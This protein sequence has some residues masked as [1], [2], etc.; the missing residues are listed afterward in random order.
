MFVKELVVLSQSLQ[1]IAAKGIRKFY[2]FGRSLNHRV[3][4]FGM[5]DEHYENGTEPYLSNG[6]G[7]LILV[8][9]NFA[10]VHSYFLPECFFTT[11]VISPFQSFWEM[12]II[13]TV[14]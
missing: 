10:N 7:W 2:S 12:F 9:G 1:P 13:F 6:T 3:L 5:S 14:T 8:R 4:T 11:E